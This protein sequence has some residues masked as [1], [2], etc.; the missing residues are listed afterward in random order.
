MIDY[1]CSYVQLFGNE[2]GFGVAE[3]DEMRLSFVRRGK[4][5]ELRVFRLLQTFV[6]LSHKAQKTKTIL[7]VFYWFC[8]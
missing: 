1:N 8:I 4:F 3:S 6:T 5:S 2:R 7:F